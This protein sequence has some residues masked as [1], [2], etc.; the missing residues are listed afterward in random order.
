MI[1]DIFVVHDTKAGVFGQ[2][3]YAENISVA[4]R[5]F[6]Y[7]AN[8]KNTEIGKYPSDFNLYHLGNYDD[9]TAKFQLQDSPVHLAIASSL[10]EG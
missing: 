1:K 3:F 9:A 4:M 7:A 8:D 10:L 6:R 2:P 5:S